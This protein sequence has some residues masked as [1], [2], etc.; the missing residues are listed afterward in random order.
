MGQK[1]P[2]FGL[3][4]V[5]PRK[6]SEASTGRFRGRRKQESTVTLSRDDDRDRVAEDGMSTPFPRRHRVVWTYLEMCL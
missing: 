3:G 6:E 1:V 5:G 4:S 2:R